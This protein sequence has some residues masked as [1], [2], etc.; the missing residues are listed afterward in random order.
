MDSETAI[1]APYGVYAGKEDD[2]RQWAHVDCEAEARTVAR[3]E[4]ADAERWAHTFAEA[5]NLEAEAIQDPTAMRARIT[6]WPLSWYVIVNPEWYDE[7][8]GDAGYAWSGEA[9]SREQAINKALAECWADNERDDDAPTYDPAAHTQDGFAVYEAGPDFH[10]LAV[11]ISNARQG[12]E[13]A[14]LVRALDV[15]DYALSIRNGL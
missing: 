15:L 2:G 4:G 11:D 7:G 12:G 3:F 14:S 1:A 9:A 10:V 5:R 6:A 8:E 13:V